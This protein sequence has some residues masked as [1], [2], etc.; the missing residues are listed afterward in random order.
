MPGLIAQTT[1][2]LTTKRYS[3][4]ATVYVDQFNRL[5]FAYLQIAASAEETVEGK[6]ALA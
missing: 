4:Y 1:S 5:G 2:F 3:K 6:N